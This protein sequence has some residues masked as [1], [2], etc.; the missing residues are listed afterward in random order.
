MSTRRGERGPHGDHGQTGLTGPRGAR[1]PRSWATTVA[2]AL[3]TITM[4]AGFAF[5]KIQAD[6]A[7]KVAKRAAVEESTR[8]SQRADS[9][10]CRIAETNRSQSILLLE[11]LRQRVEQAP[12]DPGETQ[13][14]KDETLA[15]ADRLIAE[16]RKPFPE[17]CT[18]FTPD[19]PAL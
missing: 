9:A 2:I 19:V 12:L 1:G 11:T 4:V 15:L 5:S 16:A 10:I 6:N 14:E 17:P 8:E 7:I 3:F 18:S 13:A